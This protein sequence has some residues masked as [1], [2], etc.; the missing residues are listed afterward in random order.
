[1]P[2]K[3]NAA[4]S[5][6]AWAISS[7]ATTIRLFMVFGRMVLKRMCQVEQPSAREAET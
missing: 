6:I 1:M 3:L 5:R 7:V 2:R 4:S